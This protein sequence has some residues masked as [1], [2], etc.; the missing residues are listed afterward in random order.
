M[1]RSLYIA[2]KLGIDAYGYPCEDKAMYSM[3]SLNIRESFAR[4]KA[5]WDVL[6]K[7]NPKYLGDTIPITGDGNTTAG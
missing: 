4:A 1:S 6:V 2:R 3:F 5:F 7:R